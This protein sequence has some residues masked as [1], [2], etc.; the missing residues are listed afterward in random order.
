MESQ[1]P[2]IELK[3]QCLFNKRH[4]IFRTRNHKF[5]KP[6]Q[7]P[8]NRLCC[9][10]IALCPFPRAL[11]SARSCCCCFENAARYDS[12]RILEP[13]SQLHSGELHQL[14]ASTIIAA[15]WRPMDFIGV[16]SLPASHCSFAS[17]RSVQRLAN[18][19]LKSGA[20]GRN[21]PTAPLFSLCLMGVFSLDVLKT[22]RVPADIME[23][24][25]PA[26][27]F[28]SDCEPATDSLFP[29]P[30]LRGISGAVKE[31]PGRQT[32]FTVFRKT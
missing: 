21:L 25:V 13:K 7:S 10:S 12:C 32:S 16:K 4:A 27:V 5:Y 1:K 23:E 22:P 8:A 24:E 15:A 31:V 17:F 19:H 30:V 6:L 14:S 18:G 20:I 26:D 11:P 9:I 28:G 29:L 3:H 2:D